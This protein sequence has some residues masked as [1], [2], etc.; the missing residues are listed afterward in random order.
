MIINKINRNQSIL[1][2]KCI[3]CGKHFTTTKKAQLYCN[4]SNCIKERE[5]LKQKIIK[6]VKQNSN[7]VIPRGEY[8]NRTVLQIQCHAVNPITGRCSEKF[9]VLYQDDRTI[10]PKY[11]HK[12]TNAYQ[13][14]IFEGKNNA[15]TEHSG[16][17]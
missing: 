11:C 7:L 4:D 8:S 1:N 9:N 14:Q 6:K 13:R 2:K 3:H 5:E 12:H 10:Y 15:S 17:Q 16:T